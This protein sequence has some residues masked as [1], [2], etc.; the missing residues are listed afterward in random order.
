MIVGCDLVNQTFFR[1]LKEMRLVYEIKLVVYCVKKQTTD[2]K[3]YHSLIQLPH[4]PALHV[5]L[6]K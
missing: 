2:E 3:S 6:S 1:K 5:L 4:I